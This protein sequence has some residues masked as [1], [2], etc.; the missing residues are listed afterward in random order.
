MKDLW[1]GYVIDGSAANVNRLRSSYFYWKYPLEAKAAYITRENIAALLDDL[2][3][4]HGGWRRK[5]D[6]FDPCE[7]IVEFF[8]LGSVLRNLLLD[9]FDPARPHGCLLGGLL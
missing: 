7:A 2:T 9:R 3:R 4:D 6:C 5:Q 1:R 8:R